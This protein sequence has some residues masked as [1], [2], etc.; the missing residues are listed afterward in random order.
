MIT[1]STLINSPVAVFAR[2]SMAVKREGAMPRACPVEVSRSRLIAASVKL[3][4]ASPWH[5]QSTFAARP[6]GLPDRI[7]KRDII[8][9]IMRKLEGLNGPGHASG[10]YPTLKNSLNAL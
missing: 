6:V 5:H 7:R 2:S 4:G 9:L 1:L 8:E 10:S 3:H